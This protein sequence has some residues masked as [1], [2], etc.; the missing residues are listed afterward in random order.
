M[1]FGNYTNGRIVSEST[2]VTN[3]L[4]FLLSFLKVIFRKIEAYDMQHYIYAIVPV[5]YAL[6]Q[7]P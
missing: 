6:L 1:L 7:T 3:T 2:L 4:F 5:N